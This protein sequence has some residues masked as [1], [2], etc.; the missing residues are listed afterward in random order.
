MAFVERSAFQASLK[1]ARSAP[2]V[3]C[4]GAALRAAAEAPPPKPQR[5]PPVAKA[6]ATPSVAEYRGSNAAANL[7]RS[8]NL[9]TDPGHTSLPMAE[10]PASRNPKRQP[11]P[12]T[13][14]QTNALLTG[15]GSIFGKANAS[16]G[17]GW[18]PGK[19]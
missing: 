10:V 2:V 19:F 8:R 18:K 13:A 17:K 14:H 6:S 4:D 5:R 3:P 16:T 7:P 12:I 11:N 9:S 15:S 1:E